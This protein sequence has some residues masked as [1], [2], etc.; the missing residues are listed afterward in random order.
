MVTQPNYLV[1]QPVKRV[2]GI[3]TQECFRCEFP[4]SVRDAV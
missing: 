4:G 1:L 2:L 3:V